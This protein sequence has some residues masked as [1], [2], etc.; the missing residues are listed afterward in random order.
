MQSLICKLSLFSYRMDGS[1]WQQVS[2]AGKTINI[3]RLKVLLENGTGA[4]CLN[5]STIKQPV[6]PIFDFSPYK[7]VLG[8]DELSSPR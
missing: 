6:Q 7:S 4:L 2:L 3:N 8:N 5:G 1:L